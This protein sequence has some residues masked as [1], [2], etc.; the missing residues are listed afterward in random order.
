MYRVEAVA[1]CGGGGFDVIKDV[2]CDVG[3]T[4]CGIGDRERDDTDNEDGD[5]VD[6]DNLEEH[7]D[8]DDLSV[9]ADDRRR[10]HSFVT[11]A[12]LPGDILGRSNTFMVKTPCVVVGSSAGDRLG[13][14]LVRWDRR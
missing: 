2:E 10:C 7:S 5:E 3:N 6:V 4:G 8:V 9:L 1:G 14:D 11:P 13:K 12:S